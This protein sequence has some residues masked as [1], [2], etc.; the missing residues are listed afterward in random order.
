MSK[1]SDKVTGNQVSANEYNNIV[2]AS[3]NSIEN[4]GQ[5]IDATNIQLSKSMANNAAVATFY[6]ENGAADV[7]NLISIDSFEG[8]TKLIDG[9]EARFRAAN[10]NTGASTINVAG[11]GVRDIKLPDGT[12]DPAAGDISITQDTKIRYDLTNDVWVL[13]NNKASET[14]AG[15][16]EIATQGEVDAG[17]DDA[18]SVTPL[19]LRDS[20]YSNMV[21][22]SQ[23]IASNQ[24]NVDIVL[25]T[26]TY[27]SFII[28]LKDVYHATNA[29]QARMRLS[30]D[31]GSSFRAG[32]SD[33]AHALV[34]IGLSNLISDTVDHMALISESR[35]SSTQSRAYSA[36]VKISSTSSTSVET[37]I[38]Y[39][40]TA[41]DS[42][43]N[44]VI[45]STGI[46][47]L[48]AATED[49]DAI[50]FYSSSGNIT[51]GTYTLYGIKE[52]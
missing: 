19:K 15:I 37:S 52:G 17:T 8:L 41:G 24:A 43:G 6:T 39:K 51:A 22:L 1:F 2:R 18:R 34:G 44:G 4:A 45:G 28:L 7:Y 20:V 30:N 40:S 27:D 49:N 9:A 47:R 38:E 11:T 32:A 23:T 50:R 33:Y 13:D 26:A 12:T 3:K 10:V 35:V 21:F 14:V 46:G 42:D 25:D 31:G 48:E 5:I 36:T 16:Q 29:T